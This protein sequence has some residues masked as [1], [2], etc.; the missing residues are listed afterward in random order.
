MRVE[1]EKLSRT[2]LGVCPSNRVPRSE[3]MLMPKALICKGREW[4]KA[5]VRSYGE[6][7]VR[8][9]SVAVARCWCRAACLSSPLIR[10]AVGPAVE[11]QISG[12]TSSRQQEGRD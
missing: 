6:V 10:L 1:D 9:A 8:K 11:E 7:G 4:V 12:S 2:V 5:G 3:S